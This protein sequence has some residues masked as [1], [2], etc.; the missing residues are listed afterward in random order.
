MKRIIFLPIFAIFFSF[1]PAVFSTP[2]CFGPLPEYLEKCKDYYFE[3]EFK[4]D[5]CYP[6]LS[7]V[8]P[9]S[10]SKFGFKYSNHCF[11]LSY[12]KTFEEFDAK[13]RE[14]IIQFEKF[15]VV[16]EYF[17]IIKQD[18]DLLAGRRN[19]VM[20]QLFVSGLQRNEEARQIL[21]FAEEGLRSRKL[22]RPYLK[23]KKW[24]RYSD[25]S[26]LE[27]CS[28][29]ISSDEDGAIKKLYI[30]N[31]TCN[32][33]ENLRQLELVLE[34]KEVIE[35]YMQDAQGKRQKIY[36]KPND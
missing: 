8:T 22:I 12:P 2:E 27:S 26:C 17:K 5:N 35:A 13:L 6:I 34:Q 36:P 14:Q 31:L 21:K 1:L 32:R 10:Y 29:S 28:V 15:P 24:S 23:G 7:F 20:S 16:Q 33:N 25:C 3:V 11:Y 19:M 30:D 9:I 18:E 4:Q